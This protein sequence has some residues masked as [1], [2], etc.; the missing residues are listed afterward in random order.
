MNLL[1]RVSTMPAARWLQF[2]VLL[3]SVALTSACA[4]HGTAIQQTPD[5]G[6]AQGPLRTSTVNPRYFSDANGKIV[7]L[8]GSH[9]W[10]NFQD[11]GFSN[12]PPVFDYPGYLAFL[13]DHHLN[14][15]RL[16]T[17][18]Q[19]EDEPWSK[20]SIYFTPVPFLRT[21][22][23]NAID[24]G[25][26]FDLTR[27]DER[28]FTRLRERVKAA[29]DR[30]IYVS[31]M[32]FDGEI[33]DKS[34]AP[35]IGKGNP[36]RNH[37]FNR[38][39][40]V[41]SINGDL[42]GDGQGWEID[43]LQDPKVLALQK[44]YVAKV[45]DTVGDLDNV[46]YEISNETTNQ[47]AAWQHEI[48]N[49]VHAYEKSRPKQHPVGMTSAYPD[50]NNSD[51]WSS[52][53]DWISPNDTPADPYESDPPVADGRKVI[54]S[55][56]DHLWGIGGTYDWAWKSFTRGHNLLFMD[57][58]KAMV[59]AG[60]PLIRDPN[61][62]EKTQDPAARIEWEAL[63]RN[64]GY[65]RTFAEPMNLAA[66]TPRPELAST[67]FCIANPGSEY[68]IYLPLPRRRYRFLRSVVTVDLSA[69][70]ASVQAEWFSPVSGEIFPGGVVTGG[71]K[72]ELKAPFWG[73][74]VLHLS[75]ELVAH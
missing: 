70:N 63:R 8:A 28:Y 71:G 73:A 39:N 36:W 49:F 58:Y 22:P 56:T 11:W 17:F 2:A 31:V 25:L 53:A 48:I 32:L 75:A 64:L 52:A 7:Y 46:L 40:N 13:H 14:F 38:D 15:F 42:N 47:A 26:K 67:H 20:E 9:T 34:P 50:G 16:W 33:G 21:G 19:T 37:P 65:I 74:A 23:G 59:P 66:M 4:P 12:P 62:D 60:V 41:N 5:A 35:N 68:L 18:E 1:T 44:A 6:P 69:V 45:I 29:G 54:V 55:D 61:T 10:S 24:G 43:T 27:Y 51:L 30:G 3:S 57:P 72:R